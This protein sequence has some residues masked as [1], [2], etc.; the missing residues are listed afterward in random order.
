MGTSE[1]SDKEEMDE[2]KKKTTAMNLIDEQG[3]QM[4]ELLKD[5][6]H[7]LLCNKRCTD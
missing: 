5:E 6:N 1:A 4:V 7:D 2:G 3:E